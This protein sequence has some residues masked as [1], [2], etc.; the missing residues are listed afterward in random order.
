MRGLG[1]GVWNDVYCEKARSDNLRTRC[2]AQ[3]SRGG[4]IVLNYNVVQGLLHI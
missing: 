4:I 1:L 2:M 3:A